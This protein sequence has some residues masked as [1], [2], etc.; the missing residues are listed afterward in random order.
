MKIPPNRKRFLAVSPIQK[1]IFY[2]PPFRNARPP[3]GF[4]LVI[5]LTLL[6]LL[7]VIAVALLSLASVSLRS[8]NQADDAARA[9]TN[10]RMA[11]MTALGE[12]Q[13]HAGPDTR[14][15]ATASA[16]P[17]ALPSKEHITGVWSSW[18][19]DPASPPA[20]TEY[21][22]TGGKK[23]RF[24]KWLVSSPDPRQTDELEFAAADELPEKQRV[25]LMPELRNGAST[26]KPVYGGLVPVSRKA[27]QSS[28]S[29]A[30]AVF[31]EGV[32]ARIDTGYKP[33]SS[34]HL[35]DLT[36][37]MGA[38]VRA[39]ASRISGLEKLDWRAAD[40]SR[41]DS[42]L[43]K[44]VS[45]SSAALLVESLGG[46]SGPTCGALFHEITSTSMGV[47]AD[48]A[49]GGLKQDLN[50]ILN[51][52]KLPPD[53]SGISARG[54]VYSSHLGYVVPG[55]SSTK[56]QV[57]PSWDQMFAF[58]NLYKSALQN[59]NGPTIVMQGPN[60]NANSAAIPP[61]PV[62]ATPMLMPSLVKVQLFFSVMAV[63]LALNGS[64][65][66]KPATNSAWTDTEGSLV[67]WG[68]TAWDRGARYFI[69]LCMAPCITIH[70]PYNVNLEVRDLAVNI[71]NLPLAIQIRRKGLAGESN[72][73]PVSGQGVDM[74]D[75]QAR[76]GQRK[77]TFNL[78][79][80]R[81]GATRFMLAPGEV[82]AFMAA[83]P[84]AADY[85]S[86]PYRT[87]N[88]AA[89]GTVSM[90]LVK[91]S[92]GRAI[93][94]YYPRVSG[95]EFT[96][97]ETTVPDPYTRGSVDY[98]GPGDQIRF[99]L[100]PCLD[101]RHPKTMVD[102]GKVKITMTRAGAPNSIYN[103][104]QYDIGTRSNGN[105]LTGM[106]T[107]LESPSSGMETDWIPTQQIALARGDTALHSVPLQGEFA[108][109]TLSAKTT[110][111]KM[112]GSNTEGAMA[113][114]PLAFHSPARQY[115]VVS[116]EET[117]MESN[118]FEVS[119]I[120]LDPGG[121]TGGDAY[122]E[123]NAD[124]NGYAISG[125]T[126]RR[127][128]TR[129]SIYEIPMGPLQNFCQLNS[130]NVATTNSLAAFT[131]PIGNS[132]AHPMIPP[133]DVMRAAVTATTVN[134]YDH[135]FLL[136][137]L[138]YD[139][140]YFSGIAP[141]QGRFAAQTSVQSIAN[142]FIL[143]PYD[144][145][146]LDKRLQPYFPDGETK[147]EAIAALSVAQASDPAIPQGRYGA[148]A[149]QLMK[150]AFNVNSTSKSAWKAMLSSLR[151]ENARMFLSAL[152]GAPASLE[153]LKELR[154]TDARF[155]RFLLPNNDPPQSSGDS[156]RVFQGPRDISDSELDEL[157]ENIVRQVRLRGP[158]LS[159]AEFVNRRLGDSELAQKGA[160]QAAIDAT[161]INSV[162]SVLANTG[163]ELLN[164][165]KYPN[166]QAMEG[167]S[168]QGAPGYLT[169]ADLL[170]VLGNA[171]TVRSD[172]FTVRAYGDARDS[173]GN[174]I[175]RA[176]CEAVVQR[177]P[178]YVDGK[179]NAQTPI[180]NLQSVTNKTFG[181]KFVVQ[182]FRWLSAN[183]M[184]PVS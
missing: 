168:D 147:E 83:P 31:D 37:T 167:R 60:W 151:P 35:G 73:V 52:E 44:V 79:D 156:A 28:G 181:R 24:L 59:R 126:A 96:G 76:P 116:V 139:R 153:D 150:G 16:A 182:S 173:S 140:Y 170:A 49:N 14:I 118:A 46:S 77:Y 4:A 22:K 142:D 69:E 149:R 12:L 57:E 2:M 120:K 51:A 137:S 94:V 134:S 104:V 129:A 15:T 178:E 110:H 21:E 11:L 124:G 17:D 67:A 90:N 48:V 71:S 32:K 135:S 100:R 108:L 101:R 84:A 85:R 26:Q 33:V 109:L 64:M 13:K 56:G 86:N 169:Q 10:A 1:I 41:S 72:W 160:L 39:D 81:P 111:G 61:P 9:R 47:F 54:R 92:Q 62:S 25:V 38:G 130:V 121:G 88:I 7:T 102:Q 146:V 18:K 159:M 29:L 53:F 122:I 82:R 40:L 144:S 171:A 66:Q 155:S 128:Q 161:R 174:V 176:W 87:W 154:D 112:G 5:T 158:F 131:Y 165:K 143:N 45:N 30:Y 98:L 91:G 141:R 78:G 42:A 180:D 114:K 27:G 58:A 36:A 97:Y 138:L 63:P 152:G 172:T 103:V 65:S 157:A 43:H 163:Y 3:G 55:Y 115:S 99:R 119:V 162:D 70:N 136:N 125:L 74:L 50:S 93:G 127:G 107:A 105:L 164:A 106:E 117:G 179:D 177:V 145:N 148:A 95:N 68:S 89:D 20:Q 184:E 34:Q 132:W 8:S 6:I 123:I 183:E 166:P 75:Q 175:S 80:G 113:A 19:I 133:T 23:K